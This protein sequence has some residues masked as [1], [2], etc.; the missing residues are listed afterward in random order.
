MTG[1]LRKKRPIILVSIEHKQREIQSKLLV[2]L[3][4]IDLGYQVF[5]GSA[6]AIHEVATRANCQCLILHKGPLRV[7]PTK[8]KNRGHRFAILDEEGGPSVPRSLVR[9]FCLSRYSSLETEPVDL[10]MLP[11]QSYA[12]VLAELYPNSSRYEVTGWPRVDFWNMPRRSELLHSADLLRQEYGRFIL[13]PTSFGKI[14]NPDFIDPRAKSPNVWERKVH[15]FRSEAFE[16]YVKLLTYMDSALPSGWQII[17]RPHQS[18]RDADWDRIVTRLHNV[19]VV[20]KG[21]LAPWISASEG[22][23]TWGSAAVLEASAMGKKCVSFGVEEGIGLTDSPSFELC[24][25][26]RTEAEALDALTGKLQ[27]TQNLESKVPS[28]TEFFKHTDSTT[29]AR[30]VALALDRLRPVP[31]SELKIN[32]PMKFAIWTRFV[33]SGGKKLLQDVGI[34]QYHKTA[35]EKLSGSLSQKEVQNYSEQINADFNL[36][37][38]FQVSRVAPML[39]SI[40]TSH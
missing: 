2:A 34:L 4:L 40:T 15:A 18:E 7:R 10:V 23:L 6:D 1:Q 32:C 29:S 5:F 28:L 24:L 22:L 36:G 16:R 8:Y 9:D 11:S 38:N 37:V 27:L 17:V 3:N 12:D 26:V 19:K 25:N 21:P 39:V 31:V 13:F 20:R 30:R 35:Y 14:T 33:L